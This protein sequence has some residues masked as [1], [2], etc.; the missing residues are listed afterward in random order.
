MSNPH[1]IHGTSIFYLHE[2]DKN[3]PNSNVG[4]YTIHGSYGYN[5]CLNELRSITNTLTLMVF[6]SFDSSKAFKS[7]DAHALHYICMC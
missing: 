4:K 2:N 1:R 3:Q 6:V 7:G 5:I